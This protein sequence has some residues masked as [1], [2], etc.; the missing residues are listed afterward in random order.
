MDQKLRQFYKVLFYVYLAALF[1]ILFNRSRYVA[2]TPYW[3]QLSQYV[4][5]RPFHTISLYWRLLT[6]P[7]RPILTKL[8]VYNLAGN[9]LLFLPMG[10]LIPAIWPKFRRP[11]YVLLL[12]TLTVTAA[13]ILQ[14]LLLAGSCDIDDLI[15]NL[16]GAAIGYPIHK[17]LIN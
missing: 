16:L 2:G 14:V 15:L 6:N 13:E 1:W 10:I 4:N 7:V 17:V 5:L 3:E 11:F 8:A 12:V 9:I